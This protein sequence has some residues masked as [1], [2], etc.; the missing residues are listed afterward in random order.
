M[1][2]VCRVSDLG[3]RTIRS[4]AGAWARLEQGKPRAFCTPVIPLPTPSKPWAPRRSSARARA[5]ERCA[6][7]AGA[8]RAAQLVTA[9]RL[10]P[11][12][13]REE[14]IQ[15]CIHVPPALAPPAPRR[16]HRGPR[17]ADRNLVPTSEHN[18]AGR[19]CLRVS[20]RRPTASG[21]PAPSHTPPAHAARVATRASAT[22]SR[23][24]PPPPPPPPAPPACGAPRRHPLTRP[25]LSVRARPRIGTTRL[26]V[27]PRPRAHHRP[28]DV[29]SPVA[30]VVV[31][32]H[33]IEYRI[34]LCTC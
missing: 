26:D 23:S 5:L 20:R 12:L 28:F 25:H 17:G 27:P 1:R 6:R 34:V 4:S 13:L 22:P 7:A 14:N 3:E 21:V 9:G 2:C 19:K 18:C 33:E 11:R 16:G 10:P 32:S 15:R 8:P 29:L 31:R 30:L 24:P